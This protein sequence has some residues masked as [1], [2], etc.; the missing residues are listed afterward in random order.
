M[1]QIHM[2]K[3]TN[4]FIFALVSILFFFLNTFI[5]IPS[6]PLGILSLEFIWNAESLTLMMQ[7]WTQAQEAAVFFSLGIDYLYIVS[8][9]TLLYWLF[10][11]ES[12]QNPKRRPIYSYAITLLLFSI[13]LCDAL[14]NALLAFSMSSFYEQA[15]FTGIGLQQIAFAASF[16]AT[17]KFIGLVLAVVW[18][19][20]ARIQNKINLKTKLAMNRPQKS[21]PS[22]AQ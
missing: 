19:A 16:F 8:Y 6:A 22:P 20:W 1:N 13:G 17:L 9:C 4:Y 18:I 11:F 12:L 3:Y 14:E 10:P 5:T 2:M 15:F 21:K 7:E